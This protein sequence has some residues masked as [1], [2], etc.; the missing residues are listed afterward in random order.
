MAEEEGGARG[1]HGRGFSLIETTLALGLL[2]MALVSVSGLVVLGCRLI[3]SAR[4]SSQ[5]LVVARGILEEIDGWGFHQT[6][7]MFGKD[8]AATRYENISSTTDPLLAKWRPD[9]DA[10]LS[11]ARAT[12]FLES[13]G[14]EGAPPPELRISKAIRVRV[15][16]SWR[17]GSRIREIRLGT[18]RM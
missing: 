6:Y 5:A 4:A 12:V 8:G 2:A 18:V 13:V 15:L 11:E 14:P 10:H 9:L 3:A 17:E 16:V 7:R 1:K